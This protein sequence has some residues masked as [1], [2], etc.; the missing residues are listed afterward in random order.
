MGNERAIM[1]HLD[2]GLLPLIETAYRERWSGVI[3]LR[4]GRRMGAAWLVK[5]H[6]VHAVTVENGSQTEGVAA[7]EAIAIWF[8]GTYFLEASALPPE[9]T[10]R[11]DMEDVLEN[12]RQVTEAGRKKQ[13]L[14]PPLNEETLNSVL[15]TLRQRVPGLESLS[16]SQGATVE[17]T[18]AA[19]Q[20]ER[21][22]VSDQLRQYYR[23]DARLP[24]RLLMQHG[25]HALL[26]VQKGRFATVLSARGGTT[27][28][29][30]LWAG[31]EVQKRVLDSDENGE[32]S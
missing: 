11:L 5:G 6:A 15:K 28:E 12:L 14:A 26:I 10:I 32:R 30:L 27:P 2:H 7:L 31:E 24:E 17:A 3:R 25:D 22:W 23:D 21:E 19:D 8:G 13:I 20:A 18:T 16:L 9:R 29:A 4:N 1:G